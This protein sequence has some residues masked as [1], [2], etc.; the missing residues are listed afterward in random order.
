M[1]VYSNDPNGRVEDESDGSAFCARGLY[2]AKG[3]K[4]YGKQTMPRGYDSAAVRQI[5]GLDSVADKIRWVQRSKRWLMP[6]APSG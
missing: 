5:D 2:G 3:K 6:F 4:G 1:G